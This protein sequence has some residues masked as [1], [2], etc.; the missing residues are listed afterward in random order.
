MTDETEMSGN[1]CS[2]RKRQINTL[3]A[4]RNCEHNSRTSNGHQRSD[5]L[6]LDNEQD[7][8]LQPCNFASPRR[9]QER[10]VPQDEV[11]EN[12]VR[13][14]SWHWYEK[15][16]ATDSK[17]QIDSNKT[18]NKADKLVPPCLVLE[19][20]SS[21]EVDGGGVIGRVRK[22]SVVT[23]PVSPVSPRD[24]QNVPWMSGGVQ[25]TPNKESSSDLIMR[26]FTP[27]E[28]TPICPIQVIETVRVNS[29]AE[30][31]KPFP[32]STNNLTLANGL[33]GCCGSGPLMDIPSENLVTFAVEVHRQKNI[34]T[35]TTDIH[36][37]TETML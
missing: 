8:N 24:K 5:I 2:N 31:N 6:L 29:S 35:T 10:V 22:L 1:N 11:V 30:V 34:A 28:T 12:Y 16:T 37:H 33:E 26:C 17:T 7:S 9:S 25:V 20:Q 14:P 32:K 3:D 21:S 18:V 36:G 27:V 19:D 4:N 13:K 23:P 15:E